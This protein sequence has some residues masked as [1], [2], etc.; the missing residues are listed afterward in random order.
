MYVLFICEHCGRH[1]ETHNKDVSHSRHSDFGTLDGYKRSFVDCP[2]F[3]QKVDQRNLG[4]GDNFDGLERRLKPPPVVIPFNERK[5][6]RFG[7]S[8]RTSTFNGEDRRKK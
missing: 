5:V 4:S 8:S 6:Q 1:R 2:G 3:E 7:T